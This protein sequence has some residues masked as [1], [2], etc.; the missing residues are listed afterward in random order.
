MEPVNIQATAKTP[1][2]AFNPEKGFL[3]I[4]GKSTPED[5]NV[6]YK[7]LIAW[8]EKYA[9]NPPQKTTVDVHLEHFD[10]SSSKGLLDFLKRLKAIREMEKEVEI[11]WHY[12][13]S[14]QDILEAGENFEHITGLPFRMAPH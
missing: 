2:I 8:C 14:D 3:E 1:A 5:S 6:F 9:T 4:R 12:E 7:P 10:T 11:V 13:S